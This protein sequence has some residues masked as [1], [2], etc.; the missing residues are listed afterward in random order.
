V[1]HFIITQPSGNKAVSLAEVFLGID[2]TKPLLP[3]FPPVTGPNSQPI[4]KVTTR[5][6]DVTVLGIGTNAGF[7]TNA[8]LD[9]YSLDGVIKM[10]INGGG[11]V[12]NYS[13]EAPLGTALMEIDGKAASN[14]GQL[15]G[16]LPGSTNFILARSERDNVQISILPSPL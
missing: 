13:V 16:T 3:Y 14:V 7:S 1:N 8:T 2:G 12:A 10:E 15:V 6:G 4:C 5:A 9:F 11:V